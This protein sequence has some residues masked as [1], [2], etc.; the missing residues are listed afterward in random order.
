MILVFRHAE[1]P[2]RTAD[3]ALHG[4]DA[5]AEYVINYTGTG[6]EIVMKGADMMKN[7]PVT[8]PEKHQ[9]ELILYQK[10]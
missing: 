9:S 2:Y 4:L 7:L 10:R 3:L 5:D 6:Q 1:S 8:I